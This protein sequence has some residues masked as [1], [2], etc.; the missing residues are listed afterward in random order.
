MNDTP[1]NNGVPDKAAPPPVETWLN[2][3]VFGMSLTSL[4]SDASHE[5][6]TSVLPGFLAVLGVAAFFLGLIEG[7]SDA[8]ASFVK[9]GASW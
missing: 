6:A 8:V 5:M 9:L 4:L 1:E 3:N 2:R 7:V